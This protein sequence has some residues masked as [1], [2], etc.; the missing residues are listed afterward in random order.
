MQATG[1]CTSDLG[2]SVSV[3]NCVRGTLKRF[4]SVGPEERSLELV[5]SSWSIKL[6]MACF[7]QYI[8]CMPSW[9]TS[10][11]CM[12]ATPGGCRSRMRVRRASDACQM[13]AIYHWGG[14]LPWTSA[15]FYWW[16]NFQ[17]AVQLQ[18]QH[19]GCWHLDGDRIHLFLPIRLLGTTT[20]GVLRLYTQIEAILDPITGVPLLTALVTGHCRC[21]CW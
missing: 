7:R 6:Q 1:I 9:L 21:Q 4:T 18:Q 16:W 8:E 17:N 2:V 12:C 14:S 3:C 10:V 13:G 5:S 20:R 15:V 19:S 11:V